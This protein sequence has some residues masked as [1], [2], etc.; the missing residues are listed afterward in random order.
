MIIFSK[1][2]SET[3]SIL[4]WLMS[5]NRME[6]AYD[7]EG[8]R[9]GWRCLYCYTITEDRTSAHDHAYNHVNDAGL[10]VI[11]VNQLQKTRD[12]AKFCS[13]NHE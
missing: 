7:E 10:S 6:A 13:E 9:I 5:D 2:N 4:S 1:K 3:S 12:K 11:V 8:N